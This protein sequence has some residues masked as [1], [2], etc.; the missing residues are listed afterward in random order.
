MRFKKSLIGAGLGFLAFVGLAVSQVIVVPNVFTLNPFADLV[1]VIPNGQPIAGNQYA[2]Q[3][4]ITNVYGYY[5]SIPVTNFVYRFGTNVTYAAFA[6]AGGLNQGYI[7]L[8]ANPSDGARNCIW[9]TQTIVHASGDGGGITLYAGRTTD[10]L[11]AAVTTLTAN[12]GACYL[13]SASNTSWD[14]D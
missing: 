5:K 7:Y 11:N 6:P 9:T 13:Y 10:T 4:L 8:A 14:R 3:S 12:T 2:Q 1:Q